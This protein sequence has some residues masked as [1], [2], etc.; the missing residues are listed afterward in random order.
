VVAGR[1]EEEQQK[2]ETHGPF[3]VH[4]QQHKKMRACIFLL[5]ESKINIALHRRVECFFFFWP[6]QE[7]DFGI[8]ENVTSSPVQQY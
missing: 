3:S 6:K 1:L 2:R 4:G 5:A 8:K 7:S